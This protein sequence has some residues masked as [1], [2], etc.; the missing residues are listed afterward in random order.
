MLKTALMLFALGG[1]G[2]YCTL[3]KPFIPRTGTEFIRKTPGISQPGKG[4]PSHRTTGYRTH[5]GGGPR[6]GK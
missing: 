4:V 1:I 2:L 5:S 6:L 3:A